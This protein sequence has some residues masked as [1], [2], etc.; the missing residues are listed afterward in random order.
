MRRGAHDNYKIQKQF[1]AE[2]ILPTVEPLC[3]TPS[4]QL[5]TLEE[6][7]ISEFNSIDS[8]LNII[9]GGYSVGRGVNNP[10]SI[11]TRDKLILAFKLLAEPTNS[12]KAIYEL[13]GVPKSTLTKISSGAQHIWLQEEFPEVF[14]KIQSVGK[15]RY[16][17]SSCAKGQDKKYRRIRSPDGTI[18]EVTNTLQFSREH[19][20]PNGNLCSVL[21]GNRNT[22]NGWVGI[23]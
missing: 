22:V 3:Y 15:L 20:L 13:T 10:A 14:T 5:N 17:T 19:G 1:N 16:T 12:Y 6:Y 7:Y 4:G 21:L 23:E 8:G 18:Y 11:Y 9:T 2:S